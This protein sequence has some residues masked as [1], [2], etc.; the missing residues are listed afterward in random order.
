LFH[1]RALELLSRMREVYPD[2]FILWT[3]GPLLSGAD[4]DAARNGIQ[5]AVATRQGAGDD[6]VEVWEMS[7]SND[8][9][10]CDYHPGLATHE[11]MA[12]ALMDELS[13]WLDW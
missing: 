8:D 1:D 7:I 5:S 9:P 4:L 11:A 3:V 13:L 2:A 10:G 12:D 6:A